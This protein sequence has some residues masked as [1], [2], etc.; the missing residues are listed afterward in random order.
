MWFQSLNSSGSRCL[1]VSTSSLPK[2]HLLLSLPPSLSHWC[3]SPPFSKWKIIAGLLV[4]PWL[5]SYSRQRRLRRD[6]RLKVLRKITGICGPIRDDY[7][8]VHHA[9]LL[10]SR[11]E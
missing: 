6:N 11:D 4:R 1:D 9:K 10:K 2:T 5:Q 3:H 8:A 7:V